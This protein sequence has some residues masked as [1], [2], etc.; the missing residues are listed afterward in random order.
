MPS[1]KI[2]IG[3][4]EYQSPKY[5]ELL[6]ATLRQSREESTLTQN[7]D[8][9]TPPAQPADSCTSL[10]IAEIQSGMPNFSTNSIKDL[11]RLVVE[12]ADGQFPTR[13]LQGCLIKL[14]EEVAELFADPSE[15]E[16]ADV[17]LLTLDLFHLAGVDPGKA[18]LRKM[19]INEGRQWTI[20]EKTGI[21]NHIPETP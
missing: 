17:L 4:V 5:W 20:N 19:E 15:E 6:N 21:M 16:L 3:S 8:T 11:Q 2:T 12:W 9:P 18:L 7:T 1:T 14:L 10:T 13:N